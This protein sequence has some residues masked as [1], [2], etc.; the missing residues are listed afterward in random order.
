MPIINVNLAQGHT[1]EQ[2]QNLMAGISRVAV[3][4]LAVPES[5][6]RVL[7]HEVDPAMWF[8]GGQT[9]EDKRRPKE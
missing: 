6:I 5:A 9:L 2:L 7:V 4:S 3:E 1:A 8:S